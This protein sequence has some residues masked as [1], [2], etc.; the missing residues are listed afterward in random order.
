MKLISKLAVTSAVLALTFVSFANAQSMRVSIPFGFNAG[1]KV[2]PAGEYRVELNRSSGRILL[3]DV[4][5][6]DGCFLAVKA[7][8]GDGTAERGSLF[9]NRYGDRYFLS[10]VN[11]PGSLPGASV[12]SNRTEREIAKAQTGVRTVIPAASGM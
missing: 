5:G 1:D 2:L 8:T 9:F 3:N 10:R 7:Y 6:K 12:F 4:N 11:A